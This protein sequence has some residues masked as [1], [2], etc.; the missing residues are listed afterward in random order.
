MSTVHQI[1][2]ERALHIRLIDVIF[3]LLLCYC[4]THKTDL[5]VHCIIE[6]EYR[7]INHWIYD[8][9]R[10]YAKTDLLVSGTVAYWAFFLTYILI[11]IYG[12]WF[13]LNSNTCFQIQC[14]RTTVISY[15][16]FLFIF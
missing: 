8:F 13:V 6:Q 2:L 4:L 5:F 11:Y 7:H 12:V 1:Y 16:Y 10:G 3:L 15:L 14:L 9:E